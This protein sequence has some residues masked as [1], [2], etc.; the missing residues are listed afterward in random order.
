MSQI[1]KLMTKKDGS[2][3]GVAIRKNKSTTPNII[4]SLFEIAFNIS[5]R[6]Q[7]NDQWQKQE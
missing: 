2:A 4:K 6:N 5:K 7:G 3:K 1:L